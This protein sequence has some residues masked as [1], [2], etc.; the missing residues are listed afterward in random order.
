VLDPK[1]SRRIF[2]LARDQQHELQEEEEEDADE[3]D[4]QLLRPRT[5]DNLD[6]DDES[7]NDSGVDVDQDEEEIF[8]RCPQYFTATDA[9]MFRSYLATRFWRPEYT[10]YLFASKFGR[11]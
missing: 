2:E 1:T 10:G 7:D 3:A 9:L 4:D 6:D 8:V 11:A 5:R